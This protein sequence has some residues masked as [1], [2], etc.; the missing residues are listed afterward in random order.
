MSDE[1]GSKYCRAAAYDI[2]GPSCPS[3]VS[4]LG[5]DQTFREIG[6]VLSASEVL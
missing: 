4:E 6:R 5:Q 2:Q 3:T 1:P